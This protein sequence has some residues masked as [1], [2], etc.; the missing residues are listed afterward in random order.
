MDSDSNLVLPIVG[1]T[2]A[3][4]M[5]AVILV[6]V[7]DESGMVGSSVSNQGNTEYRLIEFEDSGPIEITRPDGPWLVNG[8][9]IDGEYHIITDHCNI[10]LLPTTGNR[11][12]GWYT[13]NDLAETT[14]SSGIRY[15]SGD[16]APVGIMISAGDLYIYQDS[17]YHGPYTTVHFTWCYTSSETGDWA[18][19]SGSGAYV[20]SSA[21]IHANGVT[22][23]DGASHPWVLYDGINL[24]WY[25]VVDEDQKTLVG[26]T[27]ASIV[28]QSNFTQGRH[29]GELSLPITVSDATVGLDLSISS[30]IVPYKTTWYDSPEQQTTSTLLW[31][32]PLVMVVAVLL[33][34]VEL[35]RMREGRERD[36]RGADHRAA[37]GAPADWHRV[38]GAQPPGPVRRVPGVAHRGPPGL[39]ADRRGPAYDPAA[40]GR[41]LLHRAGP[42]GAD[43]M[44]L[45]FP[46]IV[47][48]VAAYFF[49]GSSTLAGLALLVVFW[50]I[51]AVVCLNFKASP[52]YS[53]V[54]MIPIAI[55]FTA[56][57]VL[58]E[59]IMVIII[60]ITSVLVASEFKRVA[61]RWPTPPI[62]TRP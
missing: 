18:M 10:T 46:S 54:P 7:I 20:F 15:L 30:V 23:I 61:D 35:S 59:G 33:W 36:D 50:A 44:D 13:L 56:Y 25:P 58:N 40:H 47:D 31:T 53:L 9:A 37:G 8:K 16:S 24:A 41:V 43:P 14:V 42:E 34:A 1:I 21:D 29:Y 38:E 48:F 22:R 52:A 49:G 4:I 27:V 26:G 6:P 60:V 45:S 3:I 39:L 57:G 12:S 55:F 19:V 17:L 51:A 5:I 32:I 2:V 28:N 11:I 62:P